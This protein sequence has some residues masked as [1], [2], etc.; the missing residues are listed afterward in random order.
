MVASGFYGRKPI[1]KRPLSGTW[2]EV[3]VAQKQKTGGS[4]T[5][6]KT[7]TIENSAPAMMMGAHAGWPRAKRVKPFSVTVRKPS[8]FARRVRGVLDQELG[9]DLILDVDTNS[10]Q[11]GPGKQGYFEL[12]IF[13]KNDILKMSN[14]ATIATT[15]ATFDAI[16]FKDMSGEISLINLTNVPVHVD[17]YHMFPRVDTDVTP[18]SAFESFINQSPAGGTNAT[19]G[20]DVIGVR[21]NDSNML[22]EHY[23]VKRYQ[24]FVM[25][26]GECRNQKTYVKGRI[27]TPSVVSRVTGISLGNPALVTSF[28]FLKGISV[29][30]FFVFRAAYA[31]VPIANTGTNTTITTGA[32]Q[33]GVNHQK[34]IR[35][36][37]KE[38]PATV[39]PFRFAGSNTVNSTLAPRYVVG[40]EGDVSM[41]AGGVLP[42]F[43]SAVVG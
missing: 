37:I 42:A 20:G 3:S 31:K 1:K 39:T 11:C 16:R 5:M 28:A 8:K 27:F 23:M 7:K 33:L 35:M 6:T 25:T 40:T 18:T 9:T 10:A 41:D 36:S 15:S 22:C 17:E 13:G 2:N 21:P 29:F 30:R 38:Q 43:A 26:A 14:R 24:S 4:S 32:A 19:V 12:E 34:R